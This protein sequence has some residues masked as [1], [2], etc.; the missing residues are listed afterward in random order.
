MLAE[1]SAECSAE[2]PVLVV[3]WND[4]EAN[5]AFVD[6]RANPYDFDRIPEAERYAPLMQALRALNA[7]RSSVFTAKCDAWRLNAD[8]LDPLQIDLNLDP[9]E[10]PWGFAGYIDLVVR[11]RSAFT[12]FHRHEQLLRRLVRLAAPLDHPSAALDCVVRPAVVDLAGPRQGYAISLYVK[13][14]GADEDAALHE[15]TLALDAVVA[16]VRSKD[17]SR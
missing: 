10:A 8:E 6:L 9:A 5:L 17:F 14:L 2:D 15:W 4:P 3:P 11:Q 16:L 1:W 7:T 12:S 13:A